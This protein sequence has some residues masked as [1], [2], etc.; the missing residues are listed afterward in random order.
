MKLF[1][2]KESELVSIRLPGNN[3]MTACG[4]NQMS[5]K[6]GL[7]FWR[8]TRVIFLSLWLGLSLTSIALAECTDTHNSPEILSQLRSYVGASGNG[9]QDLIISL[10][11]NEDMALNSN[12]KPLPADS[13]ASLILKNPNINNIKRVVLAWPYSSRHEAPYAHKLEKLVGRPVV[14]FSGPLWWYPNGV[15]IGSSLDSEAMY[16]STLANVTQ[17]IQRDW[18]YHTDYCKS[19]FVLYND[20]PTLFGNIKFKLSCD[21]IKNLEGLSDLGDKSASSKLFKYYAFVERNDAQEKKYSARA[22]D[23][24]WLS[25]PQMFATSKKSE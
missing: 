15:V 19:L 12:D 21:Q 22:S 23:D 7:Q 13:L 9:D 10:I 18:R 11:G 16:G 5:K 24:L 20:R 14:G 25:Y 3:S 8:V 17:C 1:Y 6:N 2:W 4:D